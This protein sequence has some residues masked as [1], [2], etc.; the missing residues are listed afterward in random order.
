ME[1]KDKQLPTKPQDAKRSWVWLYM[2]L[3]PTLGRLR[4]KD[5]KSRPAWA[6]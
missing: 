6:T 3:I 1:G 5:H 4:K 2:P